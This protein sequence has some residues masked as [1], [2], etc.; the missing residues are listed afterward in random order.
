MCNQTARGVA[1]VLWKEFF[2]DFGF[3]RRL[4]SDRGASFTGKLMRELAKQTGVRSSYTTSYHPEGNAVCERYN[5]TLISMIAT[6][7][8]AHKQKWSEHVRYLSHAYNCTQHTIT[9]SCRRPS[10]RLSSSLRPTRSASVGLGR[11]YC[12]GLHSRVRPH[13]CKRLSMSPSVFRARNRVN[14]ASVGRRTRRTITSSV[15]KS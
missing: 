3:P 13:H 1:E 12:V 15:I 14:Y 5:R 7:T 8:E 10:L 2:L 6:L 9:L 4:H 11:A